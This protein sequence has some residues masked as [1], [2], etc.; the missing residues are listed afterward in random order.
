MLK[1]LL[2]EFEYELK[3]THQMSKNSVEA[4][5]G[6]LKHYLKYLEFKG[7]TDPKFITKDIVKSY[8]MNLRKHQTAAST[9]NRKLSSMKKFHQFLLQEKLVDDNIILLINR[10]K[11]AK[12]L[13]DVLSLEE[14]ERMIKIAS[15]NT[16][17][18]KRNLA[19][20]E[21][22]YGSGLRIS[23][24]LD[25]KINDLHINMGFI[26]VIGKGSKE[27]IVP[28]G[29]EAASALKKY[30]ESS[31]LELSKKSTPYVFL[32]RFGAPI[33][34]VGFY[35]IL[36][37]IAKEAQ[38][39]KDVSPHTLRHSFA[40]HLL[41]NGVDLRYVQEMLGH[42]DVSTTEIY[43]HINKKQLIAVYDAFHPHAKKEK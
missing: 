14:I 26:N 36:K 15:V 21:L 20:I 43:T 5:L 17:L 23:E 2:K 4:Y 37:E 33:S 11:K 41:E 12:R 35:K 34:R 6:D 32:N 25:L 39:A 1:Q 9:V 40:T 24:L 22:L 7:I 13:P 42:S 3:S 8:L 38:I 16:L 10:P 28:I 31:R 29:S 30:L 19:M 18:M 27:R